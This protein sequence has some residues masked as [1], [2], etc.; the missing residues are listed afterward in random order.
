MEYGKEFDQ[1]HVEPMHP[2]R[3][4]DRTEAEYYPRTPVHHPQSYHKHDPY[5]YEHLQYDEFPDFD[6]G[7]EG[8]LFDGGDDHGYDH[9]PVAHQ[10]HPMGR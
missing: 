5:D 7:A 8:D 3:D 9:H 10:A 2:Y 6:H 1:P 4:L